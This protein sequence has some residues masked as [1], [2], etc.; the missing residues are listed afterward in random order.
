MICFPNA[1]INIGLYITEKRPDGYHEIETLLYPIPLYDALE[2]RKS[3][4]GKTTY[5]NLGIP[6]A[7]IK[8]EETSVF[9]AYRILKKSYKLPSV[10]I[11]LYKNIPFGAGL[12]GGS[13]DAAFMLRLLNNYFQLDIPVEELEN[14]AAQLGS[15]DPFFVK[16]TPQI[17]TGRGEVLQE[18]SLS[19]SEYYLVLLKPDIHV[20]TAVAYQNIS[21]KPACFNLQ[22]LEKLPISEWK[23]HINNDFEN[24][25]FQKFPLL[26]KLKNELYASGAIYASL[27]GS[28][29]A[30]FGIFSKQPT[31][32]P[33]LQ[34]NL[35]WK[36]ML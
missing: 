6:I 8:A 21:P 24:T 28:G 29:S 19:L 13:A 10:D 12:G 1:K 15:D 35:L 34:R 23:E 4:T 5:Q 22:E 9:K 27:S 36:G 11:V 25:L 16:N 33:D 20:S 7:N 26:Q 31:L 32:S 30:L 2:I 3:T 17:A 18:V 14:Y